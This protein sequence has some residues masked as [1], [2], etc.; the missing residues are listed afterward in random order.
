MPISG[1]PQP[2]LLQVD[3]R[4]RLRR[5]DGEFAVA[6]PWYQDEETL[7]MVDGCTQPYDL[8]R[9]EKMYRYLENQGEEYFIEIQT[10]EGWKPVG[11][12]TFWPQDIPIVIGEKAC[13]GQG[14]GRRVVQALAKRAKALGYAEIFVHEIY[15][16]NLPSQ[17]MFESV[18]F[19][20]CG[21]TENGIS[22]RL[23]LRPKETDVDSNSQKESL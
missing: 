11:D 20:R 4:L 19:E 5:F 13:R 15:S 6:L 1:V 10:E 3:D 23:C 8:P 17:K 12:V 21:V 2:Q 9:L 14:I 22:Y 16:Y 7:R 18:G